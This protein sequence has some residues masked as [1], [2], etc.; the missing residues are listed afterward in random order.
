VLTSLHLVKRGE[1]E[2]EEEEEEEKN[3]SENCAWN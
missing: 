1:V 2:K 3:G